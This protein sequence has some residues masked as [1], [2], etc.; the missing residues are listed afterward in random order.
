[1]ELE[2][3]RAALLGAAPVAFFTF[4]ILQWSITSG[5]LSRFD[6]EKDLQRQYKARSRAAKAS[7]KARKAG[8]DAAAAQPD[9]DQPLFHKRAV[10]DIF[11]NKVM[12]FGS[13][14]YGTMAVLTYILIEILEIWTFLVGMLSP[15]TWID[16]I[17]LDLVIDFFVNSLTNLVAAF[18]WFATLPEYI[19]IDNGFIWLAAAYLGYL[20]GLRLTTTRG[21]EIWEKMLVYIGELKDKLPPR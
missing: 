7:R 18:V 20:G 3:I 5:R 17:G 1:M 11:H 9:Y 6:D 12:F 21:D 14:F 10:G 19:N 15:T 2:L 13:G 8:R 4:L 16:K